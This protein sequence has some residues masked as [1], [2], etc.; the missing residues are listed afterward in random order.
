MCSSAYLLSGSVSQG[1]FQSTRC[2]LLDLDPKNICGDHRFL[3]KS[4][5]REA[6]GKE[7]DGALCVGLLLCQE[8]WRMSETRFLF[9]EQNWDPAQFCWKKASKV[10][11]CYVKYPI[12]RQKWNF[13]CT[14]NSHPQGF[15]TGRLQMAA[16]SACWFL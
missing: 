12:S 2:A 6:P 8:K 5:L 9:L 14:P 15:P 11:K 3:S 7:R 4:C 10:N 13:K 16:C 1:H